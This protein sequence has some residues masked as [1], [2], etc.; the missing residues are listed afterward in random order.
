MVKS[1]KANFSIFLISSSVFAAF[2]K[3]YFDSLLK[4]G[5]NL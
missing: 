5:V 2:V 1:I 3:V 4:L